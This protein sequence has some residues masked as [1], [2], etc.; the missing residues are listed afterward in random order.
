MN[1]EST[2]KAILL[3]EDEALLALSTAKTIQRF[4]YDVE[5]AAS[6]EDAVRKATA[7]ERRVDLILMDID[8][9][10]GI[11]GPEAAQAI[12][13]RKAVPVVFLTSHAERE[14]VEKV[15]GITRYGY[16]IKNSG[17]FVL[18][19]SIEMAFEL[20]E[21]HEKLQASDRSLRGFFN[22]STFGIAITAPDGTWLYFNDRLCGM[23]GYSRPELEKLTW[24]DL[25]PAEALAGESIAYE[26]VLG[27][28]DP[29]DFGKTYIRK[30]GSA[31][32]VL[33]SPGIVRNADG[34]TAQLTAIIQDATDG[35]RAEA[36]RKES[37]FRYRSLI[38][39]WSDV[40]FCVDEN[41]RY[42]FVNQVF[43][44]T[45][46]RTTDF[47]PG[48]TFRDIYPKE[49]ADQRLAVIRKV[50]ETGESQSAEVVV[51]L[52]DRD[53]HFLAKADPVRDESGKVVR[54]LTHSTDITDRK[55]AESALRKSFEEKSFLL[56][57]L[58]HRIKN[59]L[60]IIASLVS[61]EAGQ[62]EN[63]E[64]RTALEAVKDRIGSL[65][66][67][68]GM[69]YQGGD[70][71][72]V[73]LDRYLEGIVLSLSASYIRPGGRIEVAA[74]H[75]KVSVD[76]GTA[77]PV[78][79]ILN[80]LLTNAFKHAFPGDR[81]GRI[82]TTLSLMEDRSVLSVVDDGIGLPEGFDARKPHGMGM[83]IVS[84]LSDQLKGS[85]RV[86]SAG[87]T[88]CVVEFP[89]RAAGRKT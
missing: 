33:V 4:G 72:E 89:C 64:T 22:S 68:Y 77:A 46:G 56:R 21:A 11:D 29:S 85:L 86:S 50:F 62:H 45:F 41:G 65:E 18:R 55:N 9:G 47:F 75:D 7:G 73:M 52:P 66:N 20:F 6:G 78:G 71:N 82:T 30:D 1:G 58:Q 35:K 25:T 53:L 76:A 80:E 12:L 17:D 57:E 8:L 43:A 83:R 37:D 19:A 28:K 84:L 24:K 42:E 31:L 44:S 5:I 15:R 74:I 16:V 26:S 70:S 32:D 88:R 54:C 36:A 63:P 59:S 38:E 61:L 13:A 40:V 51:P 2:R 79:L 34:S 69:L 39:H 49:H 81:K 10:K 87:G 27:G 23:L 14:M 3:V 60:S 67:L 48:K